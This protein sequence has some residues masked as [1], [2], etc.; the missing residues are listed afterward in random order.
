MKFFARQKAKDDDNITE[1]YCA[2]VEVG[3]KMKKF[4]L[5]IILLIAFSS[6]A[7]AECAWV[8]WEQNAYYKIEKG[9]AIERKYWEIIGAFPKYEQCLERK[10]VLFTNVK[11]GVEERDPKVQAVPFELVI[12]HFSETSSLH[13]QF[14]CLPDTIDPRK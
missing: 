13:Y 1:I 12:E 8:L 3:G 14:K 2:K 11:K 6:V 4:L 7:N 10:K 9:E 5:T